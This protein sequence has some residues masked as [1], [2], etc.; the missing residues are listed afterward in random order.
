MVHVISSG[1]GTLLPVKQIE[2]EFWQQNQLGGIEFTLENADTTQTHVLRLTDMEES[3]VVDTTF[4]DSL[5]VDA[6]PPLEYKAIIFEDR[7]GNGRWGFAGSI[8]KA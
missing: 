2:P 5:F 7:N 4:T 1:S 6:L 8:S 3:I